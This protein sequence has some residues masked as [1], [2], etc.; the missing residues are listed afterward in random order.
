[1]VGERDEEDPKTLAEK[2]FLGSDAGNDAY[3]EAMTH[4]REAVL[5]TAGE[6][7]RPYSGESYGSLRDRLDRAAIPESGTALAAVLEAVRDDVL[8]ES[9]L[10]NEETCVAHLQC[11][12]AVP[13]LSAEAML[14]AVNQSLDSFDQ[15]PAATVLEERLVEDLTETFDLGPDADGVLTS[16]GTQSNLQGLLLARNQYVRDTFGQSA[17]E[18][19]LP[20]QAEDMRVLCSADAHFTAEQSTAVLGLG[21]DAVVE[22]PTDDRHRMD[23]DALRQELDTLE[24]AG[25]HPF[26][27]VAT[28]GTT[29]FGSIDPLGEIAEVAETYGVW[30]HADAAFGGALAFSDEHAGR[31]DGIERA[32]SVA[33]D[34]HKLCYQPISCGAFLLSEGSQFELMARNAAYLNPAD[35]EVP[36]LVGKSLQTTRRFDALKPWVTF[37]T[38]GREGIGALVDRTV[39]LADRAAAVVSADPAFKLACDPSINTVVFRYEPTLTH[40]EL[41]DGEWSDYVNREIRERLLDAGLGVVARTTVE[42]RTHLKFTLM[43]PRTEVSDIRELLLRL[44]TYGAG[45]EAE[46]A[47]S[48]LPEEEDGSCETTA[49]AENESRETTANPEVEQ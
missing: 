39:H 9:V 48:D 4:A 32:D 30:F 22:V 42:G 14:S 2:W 36:N 34:F 49:N 10:P 44:K 16:G 7:D 41:D 35:D 27:V 29:D 38:L 20:S 45:V 15:A 25:K 1:V 40:P 11:P 18:A 23:P 43:N 19:G 46:A 28:A 6:P 31:L 8:A 3:A 5:E 47:G 12:P 37:R 13:A 17:K 21:E 33:V 26:A 24:T